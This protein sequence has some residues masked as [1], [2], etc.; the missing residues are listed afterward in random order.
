M[1]FVTA[2]TVSDEMFGFKRKVK[3][4]ILLLDSDKPEDAK[5]TLKLVEYGLEILENILEEC[6]PVN[7]S[8]EDDEEIEKLQSKLKNIFNCCTYPIAHL[9]LSSN[10]VIKLNKQEL[11]KELFGDK[12]EKYKYMELEIE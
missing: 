6:I 2:E 3:E 1:Y 7:A 8:S 9:G 4:A 12:Y 11:Y 5:A 10:M